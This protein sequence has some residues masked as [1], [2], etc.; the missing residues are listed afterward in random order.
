[1]GKNTKPF[2]YDC[3]HQVENWTPNTKQSCQRPNQLVSQLWSRTSAPGI[4][5]AWR[6]GLEDETQFDTARKRLLL[7]FLRSES[8]SAHHSI[9]SITLTLRSR[10]HLQKLRVT[11]LI[12]KFLAFRGSRRYVTVFTTARHCQYPEPDASSPHLPT[13]LP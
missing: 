5:R 10:V 3:R 12:S 6:S 13:L 4:I 1:M 9:K 7:Q 2:D 8:C 11:Q